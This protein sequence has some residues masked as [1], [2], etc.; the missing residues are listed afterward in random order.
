MLALWCLDPVPDM[1]MW[2]KA[3][4]LD[5]PIKYHS[6]VVHNDARKLYVFGGMTSHPTNQVSDELYEFHIDR[7]TWKRLSCEGLNGTCVFYLRIGKNTFVSLYGQSLPKCICT[8]SIVKCFYPS[9]GFFAY[10]LHLIPQV[11]PHG[12]HAFG[13]DVHLWRWTGQQ[14]GALK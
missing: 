14:A 3:A 9:Y 13:K 5:F 4:S 7:G 12:V 8:I 10:I 11:Q 1:P 6:V 2:R